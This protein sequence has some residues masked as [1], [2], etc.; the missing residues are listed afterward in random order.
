MDME[1]QQNEE[2]YHTP[3]AGILLDFWCSHVPDW[4]PEHIEVFLEYVSE[5][6]YYP[7]AIKCNSNIWKK[8]EDKIR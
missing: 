4:E 6:K 5:L 3:T 8:K 7:E 2:R 1:K